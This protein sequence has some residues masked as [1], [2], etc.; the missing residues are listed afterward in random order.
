MPLPKMLLCFPLLWCACS[1]EREVRPFPP[2]S[3]REKEPDAV[4]KDE[5]VNK[6]AGEKTTQHSFEKNA[7]AL[8]EGK[9][10]Y[11]RFNCVGCHAHGGGGMGP[12]LMDE[13]W[14]YGYRPEQIFATIANGRP[15]GMPAFGPHVSEPQ[16]W[17]LVAY[18]RSMGGQVSR[19]AAPNRDDH[20]KGPKPE[21]TAEHVTPRLSAPPP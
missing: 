4:T 8:S 18:V 9:T 19:I 10:L 17:Q 12:P 3:L 21:N 16:I 5:S 20:L 11:T 13:R 2:K 14:I 1:C 7:Y 6:D 15:N